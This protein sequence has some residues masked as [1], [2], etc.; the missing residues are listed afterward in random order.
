MG[1]DQYFILIYDVAQHEVRVEEFGAD[2]DAAAAAYAVFEADFRDRPD[3]EVLMVGADSLETIMKTHSHYF[4]QRV[5]PTRL[6]AD[7]RDS[8]TRMRAGVEAEPKPK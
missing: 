6:L 1:P 4:G 2:G 3:I 8:L 7:L 5:D